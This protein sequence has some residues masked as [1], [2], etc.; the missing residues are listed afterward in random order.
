MYYTKL[1]Y[2]A[3]SEIGAQTPI[4]ADCGALC[5]ARCCKG[6]Q[7]SGM[8]VFPGEES[9]LASHG[10]SL[11]QKNMDGYPVSYAFCSGRCRRIFRPL[12]CRIFPLAPFFH[13][14]TL[15]V[16]EDPRARPLCPLIAQHA[17]EAKFY[18][19]VYRAFLV[20]IKDP[21]ICEMLTHYT[22]M[23]EEYRNFWNR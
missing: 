22:A 21:V 7:G 2:D 20:L 8:I 14:N 10:F 19:A 4:S 12:S 18:D 1:Y 23:L 11:T 3:Y 17:V 15:S 6:E 13:E 9:I 16:D 5:G